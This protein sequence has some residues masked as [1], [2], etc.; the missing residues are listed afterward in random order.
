MIQ[1][2]KKTTKMFIME[3]FWQCVFIFTYSGSVY[4]ESSNVERVLVDSFVMLGKLFLRIH[5][6]SVRDE[7]NT[8]VVCM[9]DSPSAPRFL[10]SEK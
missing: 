10:H 2:G 6:I 5:S 1:L 8:F 3:P 9:N 4:N 7:G